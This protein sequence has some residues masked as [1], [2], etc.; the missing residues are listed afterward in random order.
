MIVIWRA[1]CSVGARAD[2]EGL[3]GPLGSPAGWGGVVFWKP[4]EEDAG[5][6][7]GPP[8]LPSAALAPTD[9]DAYWRSRE[10]FIRR[11]LCL[12]V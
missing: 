3:G 1:T 10:S 12:T 5:D 6:P 8:I 7:K 2:D 4:D 9:V 11:M